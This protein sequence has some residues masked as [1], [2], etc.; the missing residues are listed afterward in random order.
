M[1]VPRE[2]LTLNQPTRVLFGSW[3]PEVPGI[4]E[5]TQG[6]DKLRCCQQTKLDPMV[7]L[8]A[9]LCDATAN[10]ILI[11]APMFPEV[12]AIVKSY[13]LKSHEKSQLNH[14][15]G[16]SF[17]AQWLRIHLPMQGTRV[18]ALVREDPTCRGAT[19]PMHDNY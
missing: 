12:K 6:G 8:L 15:F 19:K 5:E 14:C 16:A 11:K 7:G 1:P 13:D 4:E 10:R 17:V 18:R 2:S 3:T 9:S